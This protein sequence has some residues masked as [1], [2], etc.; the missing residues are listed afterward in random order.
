M[1]Y[2]LTIRATYQS[3]DD[4]KEI[5]ALLAAKGSSGSIKRAGAEL[6]IE[7]NYGARSRRDAAG[8]LSEAIDLFDL[9]AD[10]DHYR[11]WPTEVTVRS[12]W[13]DLA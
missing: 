12:R 13:T 6:T 8:P 7:V 3:V 5:S 10:D 2:L 11:P 1:T 9:V 4:A